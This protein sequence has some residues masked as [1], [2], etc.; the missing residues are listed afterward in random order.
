MG[1][2]TTN[3]RPVTAS[4]RGSWVR[5]ALDATPAACC[6][7]SN[8]QPFLGSAAV[9]VSFL[10][11]AHTRTVPAVRRARNRKGGVERRSASIIAHAHGWHVHGLHRHPVVSHA[12]PSHAP[13]E[14][15]AD[16]PGAEAVAP[17][18]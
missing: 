15:E 4:R 9:T 17:V 5:L 14:P 1:T 18:E 8:E 13:V 3:V 6:R 16:A 2:E 12:V 11:S 10:H 7:S